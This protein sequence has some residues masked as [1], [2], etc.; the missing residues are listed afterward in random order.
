MYMQWE[1]FIDHDITLTPVVTGMYMH[2]G[3]FI[4]HDITLTSV[5]T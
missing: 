1:Q 2:L 3:Q 5:V 4:D